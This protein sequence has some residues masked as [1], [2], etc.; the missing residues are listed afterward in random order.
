MNE[1]A[2][3]ATAHDKLER[4]RAVLRG[5]GGALVCFSGGVDSHFLLK[6]AVDT[7][8]Q[9][10]VAFTAESA[11]MAAREAAEARKL[12]AELGCRHEV[13]HTNELERGA[14][15]QNPVNRCYF[16]KAELLEVALPRAKELDLGAIC[17]GT[18]VD[19][20]GDHRPGLQAADQYGARHPL[21]EASLGKHEIRALAHELG[22]ATW[23]KPQLACLS[24]RFPY[25]TEI[26][27]ERL[28]RVDRFEEGLRAL[29]FTQLRVRFHE[30]I[31]RLELIPAEI[32]HAFEPEVRERVLEL[33]RSCGF[34]YVAVDLAG[35]RSGALNEGIVR[36]RRSR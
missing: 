26:T 11:S 1:A 23:N 6:V 16:C 7:L 29:G 14:Y 3:T 15:A 28:E 27:P 4:L 30:P 13:V 31:A 10:A 33:S 20:L 35:Y 21:V 8:G 17:L 25:G 22:L 34:T 5:Y 24:S 12:A 32:A 9:R 18:T 36:L 2:P 19:D